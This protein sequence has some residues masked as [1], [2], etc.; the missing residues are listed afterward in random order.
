MGKSGGINGKVQIV[1]LLEKT[2]AADSTSFSW[3]KSN[4]LNLLAGT[5]E[6]TNDLAISASWS[7]FE[8]GSKKNIK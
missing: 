6:R 4:W 5:L 3:I 8:F 7:I 1:C 2:T